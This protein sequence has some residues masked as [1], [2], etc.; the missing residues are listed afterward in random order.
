MTMRT[1]ITCLLALA[2]CGC[3]TGCISSIVPKTTIKG[4]IGGAPFSLTSPKNSKLTNVEI[5][6]TTNGCVSIK[7]GS[8]ETIMDPA[9]IT[10]TADGQVKLVDA[11]VN[12]A[13]KVMSAIP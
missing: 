4:S 7:I 13:I 9:V 2:L 3:T 6:A 12:A 10:T 11:G 1:F 8:L 5:K